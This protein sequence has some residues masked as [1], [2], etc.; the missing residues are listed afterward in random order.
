MHAILVYRPK[1]Q[2]REER[3]QQ[4]MESNDCLIWNKNT[5]R[6]A[7]NSDRDANKHAYKMV[8]V[9]LKSNQCNIT[10]NLHYSIFSNQAWWFSSML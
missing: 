2:K 7:K 9:I 1:L 8:E 5:I 6:K 10:E 3:L 4:I